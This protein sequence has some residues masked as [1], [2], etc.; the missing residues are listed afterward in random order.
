[1]AARVAREATP[2][3]STPRA[4]GALRAAI[5]DLDPFIR[6]VG[7]TEGEGGALRLAFIECGYPMGAYHPDSVAFERIAED[8]RVRAALGAL[9]EAGEGTAYLAVQ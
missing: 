9:T 4:L 2:S 6:M 3:P 8:A 5:A 1:M 7:Y